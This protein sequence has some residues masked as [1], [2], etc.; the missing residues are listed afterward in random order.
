[1]P[2]FTTQLWQ[3]LI[4][5]IIFAAAMGLLEAI[6]VIYIRE[7][8]VPAG[9][10]LTFPVVPLERLPFETIREA[11]TIVMLLTAA[12]LAGNKWRNRIYYFFI[13]FGVWD[14]F[15]YAGLKLWLDWPSSWLGWDCLFL[16]PV[17]WYGPVLAPVLIS[18]Y[19][20]IAGSMLLMADSIKGI[21][22]A[23]IPGYLGQLI[24][25]SIWYWSFVINTDTITEHGYKDVAYS[26]VLFIVGIISGV[27]G[28]W[29]ML[30]GDTNKNGKKIL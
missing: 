13:M 15:Y 3:R 19:F 17:P 18:T 9:Y 4:V 2:N 27:I 5:V 14:V 24:A 12:W 25:F 29:F 22:K 6:C 26:W 11:C 28:I 21:S 20:V 10:E 16:I 23:V 30:K 8:V 7:I 1:M